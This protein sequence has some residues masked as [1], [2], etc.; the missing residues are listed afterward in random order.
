M[1]RGSYLGGGTIIFPGQYSN[2]EEQWIP[3]SRVRCLHNGSNNVLRRKGRGKRKKRRVKQ[4]SLAQKRLRLHRLIVEKKARLA[5]ALSAKE[6]YEH[7]PNPNRK[8]LMICEQEICKMKR[9]IAFLEKQYS[10]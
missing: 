10:R 4:G 8:L 2:S 5:R 9:E 7:K 3:V 6:V 1:G